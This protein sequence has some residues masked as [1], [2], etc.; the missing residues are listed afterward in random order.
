MGLGK[1]R[2]KRRYVIISLIRGNYMR[3]VLKN[4]FARQRVSAKALPPAILAKWNGDVLDE[5]FVPLP[6]RLLRCLN[7]IF[8]GGD[9][10]ERIMVVLAIADYLRPNLS[11]GPSREFLAF[12][13]GL[14][15]DR[16]NKTLDGLSADGLIA[17]NDINDDELD[18]SMPGLLSKVTELTS[19][20]EAS[21]GLPF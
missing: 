13:S 11:R 19:N 21:D 9:A 4:S 15:I 5:G 10:A 3:V 6:K 16:L 12:I 18:V 20:T 14:P 17:V 2:V 1:L 7:Q 8:Q